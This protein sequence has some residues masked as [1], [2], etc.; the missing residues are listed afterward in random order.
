[1]V[2]IT[3][4]SREEAERVGNALLDERLAA[5]VNILPVRSLYLWKGAREQADEIAL[6]AKTTED[7][8]ADL[9]R[10]VRGLHRYETP[11]VVAWPLA[12][13]DPDSLAWVEASTRP[14]PQA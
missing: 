6:L 3:C 14:L 10:L 11:C 9:T 1:M 7:R 2:Y 5:C 8:F 13:G 12:A 4:S